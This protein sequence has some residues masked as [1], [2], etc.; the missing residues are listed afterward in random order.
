[1]LL[2][3][4]ELTDFFLRQKEM[5]KEWRQ[6]HRDSIEALHKYK[7]NMVKTSRVALSTREFA[8]QG[9][10]SEID[11]FFQKQRAMDQE[12]RRQQKDSIDYLHNY[13]DNG[14]GV[15]GGSGEND[16]TLVTP[17]GPDAPLD[18]VKAMAAFHEIQ[19][20]LEERLSLAVNSP[21]PDSPVLSALLSSND[22]S[23]TKLLEVVEDPS[24]SSDETIYEDS[25]TSA[26]EGFFE[27][28][29]VRHVEAV[30][31]IENVEIYEDSAEEDSCEA[32]TVR[33]LRTVE[34]NEESRLDDFGDAK[35]GEYAECDSTVAL[36]LASEE[37]TLQI[38]PSGDLATVEVGTDAGQID[39]GNMDAE[40]FFHKVDEDSVNETD[41]Q[42]DK[43]EHAEG[44]QPSDEP[45]FE[46]KRCVVVET[47]EE[48][49]GK[50]TNSIEPFAPQLEYSL[51][52]PNIVRQT[53]KEAQR[54]QGDVK[55]TAVSDSATE[56]TTASGDEPNEVDAA[57]VAPET[58]A[59]V[60][61]ESTEAI[62]T[63]TL[64]PETSPLDKKTEGSDAKSQDCGLGVH[65]LS[66]DISAENAVDI[67]QDLLGIEK[68]E[69]C[70]GLRA[71][72][73]DDV[74]DGC[75]AE[76]SGAAS[77][78]T[79]SGER[80]EGA[81]MATESLQAPRTPPR[82][83]VATRKSESKI[84]R[85]RTRATRVD[86]HGVDCGFPHY[87]QPTMSTPERKMKNSKSIPSSPNKGRISLYSNRE[88]AESF[89]VK[90]SE[91]G[92][93]WIP[94]LHGSK[95]GCERCLHFASEAE[96]LRFQRYGH[97]YRISS[98]RGGCSRSCPCFPRTRDEQP[99]RLCRKCFYDTHKLGQI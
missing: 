80:A 68:V 10:C 83:H 72:A 48:S 59:S 67:L 92:M 13:R 65:D 15:N 78:H 39:S 37:D 24:S 9:A 45:P 75:S 53:S 7:N 25:L 52:D 1:M 96:R 17:C 32:E 66:S 70:L 50:T 63:N 23:L 20:S 16:S 19:R 55:S 95:D 33:Q 81:P 46:R 21:L 93:K 98:V 11:S 57:K 61:D 30:Q 47:G 38:E 60:S 41:E 69:A 4:S 36:L 74:T 86:R 14:A 3:S 2:S 8:S 54:V 99:V 79:Q 27:E 29:T 34:A 44:L 43:A 87:V 26:E 73:K 88:I 5:D 35:G 6:K 90:S 84:I 77:G 94:A 76:Q 62:D 42:E 51:S 89:Q 82:H 28:E 71:E 12:W 97:H 49:S 40:R 64:D 58:E 56:D 18:D 31:V 22:D 91:C 85:Q